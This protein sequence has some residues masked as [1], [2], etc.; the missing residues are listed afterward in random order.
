MDP[1]PGGLQCIRAS[2][3]KAKHI[4]S[5]SNIPRYSL[6]RKYCYWYFITDYFTSQLSELTG[7]QLCPGWHPHHQG[8]VL[9]CL[10]PNHHPKPCHHDHHCSCLPHGLHFWTRWH[11]EKRGSVRAVNCQ[12][13]CFV[14]TDVVKLKKKPT[15]LITAMI[16]R[17]YVLLISLKSHLFKILRSV[18]S[19]VKNNQSADSNMFDLT[20]GRNKGSD[21]WNIRN[22]QS[23]SL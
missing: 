11:G 13:I 21:F 1:G 17:G 8:Q 6:L 23:R 16:T 19:A 7:L 12:Y 2:P 22:V 9:W 5:F 4:I 14:L 18:S 15:Y 20:D 3:G 10:Y